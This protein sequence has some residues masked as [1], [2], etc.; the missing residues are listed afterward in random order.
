MRR[1]LLPLIGIVALSLLV[2]CGGGSKKT[3]VATATPQTSA[4]STP[5]AT[6]A[7]TSIANTPQGGTPMSFADACQK[8]N[9][10]SFS[11]AP[12]RIIDTSKTYVATIK[13]A[14]GDIV[15]QL[16]NRHAVTTNNFVFLACKGFYDGLT[17]HRVEAGFV[18]QGGA[19]QPNGQGGPGYSIPGEFDGSNFVKGVIG[20][21]RTSDPNSADSQFYIMIGDAHS[22]DGKYADFG[23]VTSGQDVADQIAVG[24]VIT[25]ITI[26]E[27]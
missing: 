23:H 18:I 10:K 4:A 9:E 3:P 26:A 21:A 24:D 17:F 15:V 5:A 25:S 16:D 22:L 11:S 2:A 12:P 27:Q 1:L 19:P 8:T 14:K 20:M 13:T 7:S 6:S